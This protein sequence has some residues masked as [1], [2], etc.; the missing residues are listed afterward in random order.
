MRTTRNPRTGLICLGT[1]ALLALGPLAGTAGAEPEWGFFLNDSWDATANHVFKYGRTT[2]EVLIGDW[3]GDGTDSI[4]VRRGD[5][6]YVSNEPRGGEAE[7][8]FVY[9]RP[10]DTVL[11]GDWNGDGK[12][13]LAVRRGAQYHV[14]NELSGG[15]ADRVVTYGRAG[16]DVVVGDWDGDGEDTFAVRR[17]KTFYV[18]NAIAGGEAD[19]VFQYGREGDIGRVDDEVLVGDWDGDGKDTLGVRRGAF[20]ASVVAV[21]DADIGSSWRPGCPV[22]PAQL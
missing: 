22:A 2:D 18:K 1:V 9:G 13:T 3:D 20:R 17:G 10:G 15:P 5:R 21:T 12:D 6:F 7:R 14:R 4:S 11:V 8:V 16:D 19:R